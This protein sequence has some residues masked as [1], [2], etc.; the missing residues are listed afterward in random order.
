MLLGC[1]RMVV[2]QER[3]PTRSVSAPT[4]V[5]T[6]R[7][8]TILGIR[9]LRDES[10]LINDG[11]RRQLIIV[12]PMHRTTTII[13]DSVGGARQAYGPRA[14]PFIAGRGDSTLFVD[15]AS[16]SLVVIDPLGR[17]VGVQAPPSPRDMRFLASSPSAVDARGSLIYRAA[18][19]TEQQAPHE[20]GS[21][22]IIIVS[23]SAPLVRANFET[24]TIDTLL[25]I[26]VNNGSRTETIRDEGGVTLS[27]KFVINPVLTIDDWAVLSD[28]SVAVVRGQDY[29]VDWIRPDGSRE[30][31][32]RMPF[33]WK[34]LDDNGKQALVDSA[35]RVQEKQL[36]DAIAGMRANQSTAT[37]PPR[38]IVRPQVTFVPFAQMAD[39]YPPLRQGALK[40]DLDGN[41][42]ILPT[43]T[44]TAGQGSRVRRGRSTRDIDRTRE[45]Y[46]WP[47]DCGLW[48]WRGRLPGK[49][50]RGRLATREGQRHTMTAPEGVVPA[51]A[52]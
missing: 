45:G 35:R 25:R 48:S 43:T 47:L 5:T 1:A 18:V 4:P 20:R 52:R 30:S 8:G 2:A 26:K 19:F 29:H 21:P 46:R 27:S 16:G 38:P 36:D 13:V 37:T 14:T 51:A 6:S 34:A 23:D 7:F 49:P 3:V 40:A 31:T 17:I 32:T 42:W 28:G 12:D 22:T 10:V 39:F 9:Q 24:R 41:L 15:G 33:A 50:K 11:E 44:Q